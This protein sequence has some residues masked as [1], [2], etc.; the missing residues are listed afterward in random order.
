MGRNTGDP[1][2]WS[3]SILSM[4]RCSFRSL[5]SSTKVPLSLNGVKHSQLHPHDEVT[6]FLKAVMSKSGTT[7]ADPLH[8]F[9]PG[10][11]LVAVAGGTGTKVSGTPSSS[12]SSLSAVISSNFLMENKKDTNP[13][14]A[15]QANQKHCKIGPGK[16]FI[17]CYLG[18][19]ATQ[20]SGR[21]GDSSENL[22]P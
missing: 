7:K 10:L 16:V 4:L 2:C 17:T 21:V 8:R 3:H 9:F 11:R 15:P 13:S 1:T 22:G 20:W 6:K 12:S 18:K 19:A 5:H 14:Y